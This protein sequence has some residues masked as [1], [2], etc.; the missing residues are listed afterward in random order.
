MDPITAITTAIVTGAASALSETATQ[1]VRDG[2]TGLKSLLARKFGSAPVK[3]IEAVETVEEKPASQARQAVLGEELADAGADAD[4][5]LL[6]AAQA[7]LELIEKQAPEAAAAVG[8]DIEKIRAAN[9]TIENVRASG[10]GVKARDVEATGDFTIKDV[11]AGRDASRG[12]RTGGAAGE[13]PP[14]KKA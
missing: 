11:T 10:A 2:Y 14:A 5:E 1:A 13:D 8:V 9:V 12:S 6:A 4:Q 7:L 3:V